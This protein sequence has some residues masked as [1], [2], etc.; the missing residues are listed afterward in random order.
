MSRTIIDT[1]LM[2]WE[3]N[4]Y[5]K[6]K[7][8]KSR[9]PSG[10]YRPQRTPDSAR[11]KLIRTI[12]R[13]PEV[14]V[15]IT[16]KSKDMRTIR[17]RVD[18][19]SQQGTVP[20]YDEQGNMFIGQNVVE[21]SL[22]TWSNGI[23]EIP[24]VNGSRPESIQITFSMPKLTDREGVSNAVRDFL[25]VEFEGY[26]YLYSAHE[27]KGHP[28]VHAVV[29]ATS[30]TGKRL[31]PRKKDLQRWREG[32]AEKL[33]DHGI[34]ANATQRKYRG[35]SKRSERTP[36]YQVARRHEQDPAKYPISTIIAKRVAE[37]FAEIEGDLQTSQYKA[38]SLKSRKQVVK[39]FGDVAKALL[40]GNSDDKRLAY[41][42]TR[43][44]QSLPPVR[45]RQDQLV[46]DLKASQQQPAT[47]KSHE[48]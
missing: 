37:A 24:E 42:V 41:D 3:P 30:L 38:A 29:K 21:D 17:R 12:E 23:T 39:R 16:S 43:Y 46:N 18:Y 27:D 2:S 7:G 28:H 35:V 33:R 25:A 45:T 15:K 32:F 44:V 5:P 19:I 8:K 14:L 31:N 34:E 36:V 4:P 1:S 9:L 22:Y 48:R 40:T 26:Q 6:V 13:V 20:V 47:D 11:S 10:S